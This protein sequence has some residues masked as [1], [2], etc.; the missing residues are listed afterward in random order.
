MKKIL[1]PIFFASFALTAVPPKNQKIDY[2]T[3][4]YLVATA[5]ATAAAVG[6]TTSFY[7]YSFVTYCG[8]YF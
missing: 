8:R 4:R 7:C 2:P 1:V 3:Y 6:A 5:Y